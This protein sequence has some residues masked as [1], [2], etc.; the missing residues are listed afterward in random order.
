MKKVL[1]FLS[2]VFCFGAMA[3]E[4]IVPILGNPA[5]F[6]KYSHQKI[7]A[8]GSSLDSTFIYSYSSLTITDIWDDFS[9]NKF[10]QYP[11]AY[12]AAN[13]T[14]QWYWHLMDQTNTT[15]EPDTV[16]FCDE[17]VAKHDSVIVVA[18][19]G[20]T[21]TSNFTPHDIWVNDLTQYP[22]SGTVMQLYDE[23]YTLIDSV[24]EGVPDPTQDTVW[25]DASTIYYQDSIH[26][27]FANMNDPSRIWVD[28]KAF[29]N[30][31]FPV[32][33]F[34]LGVATLDGV[35]STGWPY[36]FNNPN[37]YGGADTMTS[38]PI[39]LFGNTNVFLQFLY[40]AKGH[41]N[42]PEDAD[43]L[44]VDF[45]LPDSAQWYNIWHAST[46]YPDQTWD[47]AY[48]AVPVNFL[49][50]GFKFR[51]RNYAS[52]SGALDHWH[53]D[54]VQLYENPL[55]TI[56]P[57]KD[58]AVSYPVYSLLKD[59]T[60]V[61]WDHYNALISPNLKM[62][63]TSFL[64]VYNSDDTPTN[65]GSEMYLEIAYD[66][67][68]QGSYNL[69]NPGAT[70]PWTS[71]WELGMNAFPFFTSSLHNSFDA[72]G[73]DTMATFNVKVN[74]HAAVAASN[75]YQVN[76]TTYLNQEFKN[77]YAYDDGSAEVGYGINGANSQLA[78]QFTAYEE[79]TLTGV[80]MHFV[81][82]E[83]DVSG[84]VML[85]TVW[86]DNNG[87]PGDILYQDDYFQPHY[88]EYGGSQNEFRYYEFLNPNFPS[89]IPVGETF[90]VGWEQIESQN[91]YVGMDRNIIKNEKMFYNVSGSWI[92]SSSAGCL[93]I[94]PVFSTSINYTLGE[95]RIEE[96]VEEIVM[97]PNPA[98]EQV[99]FNGINKDCIVSFYDMTGRLVMSTENVS[100]IDVSS[101][102]DGIYL[103]DIRDLN[104]VSLYTDKLVKK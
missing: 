93:M 44:L 82:A 24:I 47:T 104:G 58:L 76:D 95:E 83:L 21:F 79:D 92:G 73:N 41:G 39:N 50:N 72:P 65:V 51:F 67:A 56:Q 84:Y 17:T 37:S 30:Y 99:S 27:F 87:E 10:V 2:L 29:H 63:D 59:Y 6:G 9:V 90:Y 1:L 57:L 100:G 97:F 45:Y 69:P 78:Y 19:V 89:V 75:V 8:A 20:T 62:Q 18:G 64:S 48:I 5:L 103:V 71:N 101:L 66:G 4:V 22:I 80:L 102:I 15:P 40:Q 13:V 53:I 52:L 70:P 28:N 31:N 11:P 96:Q 14:S 23:C 36:E 85:L 86:D 91:L 33:P 3:Q 74:A 7:K 54:Y 60:A 81:P 42:M 25:A 77:Y 38:K 46:P 35:D 34:S 12:N 94:R 49:D 98:N 26:L 32:D 16:Q 88:P 43:S 61:P 68:V 55:I